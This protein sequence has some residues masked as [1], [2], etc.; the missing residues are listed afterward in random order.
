MINHLT[1]KL[2][3]D[4]KLGGK[5]MV[6]QKAKGLIISNQQANQ[7]MQLTLIQLFQVATN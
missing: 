5:K 6:S 2:G 1:S 4:F 7:I 3:K